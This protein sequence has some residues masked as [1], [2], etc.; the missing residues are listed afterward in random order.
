MALRSDTLRDELSA[1]ADQL[2]SLHVRGDPLV[3][4][5]VWDVAST[6]MVERL[7]VAAI[8]TTSAGLV[9]SLG[10]EDGDSAG[11]GEVFAAVARIASSTSLPVTADIEAG[12]HLDAGELVERL[13]AA[14]AVGCN[15]EDTNHHG[16]GDA[17][18]VDAERQ[19]ARIAS[20]KEAAARAGV[21][22]VV[23]ARTD[24][25]LRTPDDGGVVDEAV[26]R[27]RL[28]VEA[29]ADCVYPIGANDEAHIGALVDGVDGPV[30]AWLRAGSPPLSRLR[31]LG[32]A[33]VSV[34]AALFRAGMRAAEDA[35]TELLRG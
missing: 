32:V 20:V 3:L 14:G 28:Y 26:R 22:V 16:D 15:L 4:L 12:Y 7:G 27:G 21:D 5:N 19:A 34:A 8:A 18:L 9:A 6:R 25:F 24:G 33:R 29:G 31:S 13:L 23:N 10:Y 35:A 30:N 1:K 11:A 2:R 17:P